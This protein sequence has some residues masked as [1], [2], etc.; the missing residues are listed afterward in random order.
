M[1]EL[2]A[3]RQNFLVNSLGDVQLFITTTDLTDDVKNALPEGYTFRVEKGCCTKEIKTRDTITDEE[4]EEMI[5]RGLS[6]SRSGDAV[7]YEEAFEK[8]MKDL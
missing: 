2:D 6:Q 8:L 1:S 3:S 7:S 5:K 4:F